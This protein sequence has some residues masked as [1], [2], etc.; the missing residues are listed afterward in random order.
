LYKLPDGREQVLLEGYDVSGDSHLIPLLWPVRLSP[1]GLWLLVPTPD[2]GTWLVSL[3]GRGRRQ[4]SPERLTATWSPDSRRIVFTGER[5]PHEREQDKEIYV[6]DVVGGE[7]RLLARLPRSA[8]YPAWSPSCDD[9]PGDCGDSV[10]A[11][12]CEIG[13]V[14]ACTVWLV[15]TASGEL[16]ALGQF[17]PQPMMSAPRTI[18]WSPLGDEVWVD[19]WFGAR[20]FPVD[21]RGV[22]P[23]VSVSSVPGSESPS[24][25]ALQAWAERASDKANHSRL[26]VARVDS[27]VRVT[28]EPA[29]EQVEGVH[30]T[31]DGRRVLVESYTGGGYNLWAVDPAVGRPELVVEKVTFLGTMSQL[32]ESST[33]VGARP[34]TWYMLPEP[35]D[36]SR[37]VR[38]DLPGIGL[39]LRTPEQWRFEM[40]GSGVAQTATL[41]NFEGDGGV[42]S[43]GGGQIEIPWQF[44]PSRPPATNFTA[45]LSQT[46]Q[47]EQSQVTA[48]AVT[49]AGRPAARVRAIVSPVSEQLRVPWGTGE[50]WITRRPLSPAQDTIFEQMLDT[51]E[52]LE[53]PGP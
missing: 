9:P 22:R 53:P 48:E 52:F 24:D 28:F 21:G 38:H 11:F 42:V 4:I 16:K 13:R 20:A 19:A 37:W 47:M 32:R 14:Y 2:D 26:V 18:R 50:L 5:G 25:G 10:A 44:L 33:E 36:P 12:S 1:D 31:A 35:D 46:V 43:L 8:A 3:D 49:V 34:A 15:D 23:L 7:P 29:F 30:W 17:A 40:R 41:T 27:D 6:Q 51:L 39:R 45:W